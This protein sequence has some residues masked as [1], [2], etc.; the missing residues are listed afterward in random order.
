MEDPFCIWQACLPC[1]LGDRRW[2][3]ASS[4]DVPTSSTPVTL[5][6]R[7]R[8]YSQPASLRDPFAS[9]PMPPWPSMPV[10]GNNSDFGYGKNHFFYFQVASIQCFCSLIYSM[11]LQFA[12]DSV[13]YSY[14]FLCLSLVNLVHD[15]SYL[16]SLLIFVF[17]N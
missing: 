7:W 11:V 13:L 8:P 5:A 2:C 10:C 12:L 4:S 14:V 6:P 17:I 16:E 15:E 3:P 9:A 1:A